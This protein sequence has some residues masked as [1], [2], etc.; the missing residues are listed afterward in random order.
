MVYCKRAFG[1]RKGSR[2]LTTLIFLASEKN[3]KLAEVA[4]MIVAAEVP[5]E[6]PG[7]CIHEVVSSG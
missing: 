1:V 2:V 6:A 5:F 7:A 4:R 3:L